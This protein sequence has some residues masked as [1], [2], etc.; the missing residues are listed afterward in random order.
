MSCLGFHAP[1]CW[2]ESFLHS[3]LSGGSHR[4]CPKALV[5]W[6][7]MMH[8]QL[9]G[10]RVFQM[11]AT[12]FLWSPEASDSTACTWVCAVDPLHPKQRSWHCHFQCL[13]H[14]WTFSK[15]PNLLNWMQTKTASE[16]I[17]WKILMVQQFCAAF[18]YL[19]YSLLMC[20]VIKYLRHDITAAQWG[21]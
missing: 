10:L 11:L 21:T 20:E 4:K 18:L 12:V 1:I 13:G 9:P 15:V 14:L 5:K 16:A 17:L 8:W 2:K 3:G 7:T 6:E 19:H